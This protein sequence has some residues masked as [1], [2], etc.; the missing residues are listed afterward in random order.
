MN[1][2]PIVFV[3]LLFAAAMPAERAAAMLWRG[4]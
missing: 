1:A 2:D 3:G 4:L